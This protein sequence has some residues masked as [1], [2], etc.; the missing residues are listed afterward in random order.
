MTNE[1]SPLNEQVVYT[2]NVSYGTLKADP[3]RDIKKSKR[4]SFSIFH[5]KSKTKS[6]ARATNEP[7]Y[8]TPKF[9]NT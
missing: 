9:P 5:R 6:T 3:V 8:P 2:F 1:I 7:G 4:E